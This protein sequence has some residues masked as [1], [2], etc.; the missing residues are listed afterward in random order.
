MRGGGLYACGFAA[1]FI[2]LEIRSFAQD[3]KEIGLLFDGEIVEFFANFVVDSFR[4]TINAFIWPAEIVQ[5][6]P[7]WG[8]I[9]LG[10]AF[11]TF[12][13]FLKK[14]IEKWLFDEELAADEDQAEG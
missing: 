2:V 11:V 12:T 13:K 1:T 9:G 3:L 6:A 7:P 10:I 4:N 8:A 5:L 14:P